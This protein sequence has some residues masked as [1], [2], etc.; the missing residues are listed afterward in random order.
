MSAV[1]SLNL[2]QLVSHCASEMNGDELFLKKGGK[3]FWPTTGKYFPAIEELIPINSEI[4][5]QNFGFVDLELC[6]YDNWFSSSCLGIFRI[7]I[8]R[9][10][11]FRNVYE[12]SLIQ[13][14]QEFSSYSLHWE[15]VQRAT[16]KVNTITTGSLVGKV[17]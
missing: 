10:T 8:A 14:G 11:K 16:Q 7:L 4:T 9:D 15:I 13:R 12:C 6:E 3:R 17:L 5:L 1:I 2:I